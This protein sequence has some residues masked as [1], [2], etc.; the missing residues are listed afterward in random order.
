MTDRIMQGARQGGP[1]L[2]GGETADQTQFSTVLHNLAAFLIVFQTAILYFTAGYWK[3]FGKVW[4]DGVATI[5]SYATIFV[6][7]AFSFA[8]L[9]SRPWLRKVNTL[10]LE[11]MHLGIAAFMG[12]VCFGLLMIGADCV[13]LRDDDY[14][15]MW[16]RA[17]AGY[18]RLATGWPPEA[19]SWRISPLTGS[20]TRTSGSRLRKEA[21]D[22]V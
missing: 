19:R 12:L 10:A 13:C 7:L 20:A 4:Q 15:S 22:H 17:Q 21:H 8:L 14:R 5:V 2:N 18:A 11:G 3:I 9:S 16:R 1:L 6:E